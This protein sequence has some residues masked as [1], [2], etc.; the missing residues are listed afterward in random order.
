MPD[1]SVLF[2][3]RPHPIVLVGWILLVAGFFVALLSISPPLPRIFVVF[4]PLWALFV[5]VLE[6]FGT[7][8]E[9]TTEA[10]TKR[11]GVV[12]RN[13][14][15]IPFDFVQDLRFR[16]N[17]LGLLFGYGTLDIE[18]AGT[19]GKVVFTALPTS[20]YR[21]LRPLRRVRQGRGQ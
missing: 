4:M 18:S 5:F 12:W 16:T 15:R 3:A 11:Q 8:Y 9:A 2:R 13:E 6:Y 17:L 21:T 10:I 20:A 7:V 14:Q 1:E 19:E